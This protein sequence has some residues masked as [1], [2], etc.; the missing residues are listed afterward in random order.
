MNVWID[1]KIGVDVSVYIENRIGIDL[2]IGDVVVVLGYHSYFIKSSISLI[3]TF[4]DVQ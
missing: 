2:N 3:F 4:F 1:I